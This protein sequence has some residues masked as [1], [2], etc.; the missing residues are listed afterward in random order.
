MT[1]TVL[2]NTKSI[3][4]Q[5]CERKLLWRQGNWV[6]WSLC[7]EDKHGQEQN[8]CL[9]PS[10]AT[11]QPCFSPTSNKVI[12][13]SHRNYPSYIQ[14]AG[15]RHQ[16]TALRA[17]QAKEKEKNSA[18]RAKSLR[19][20]RRSAGCSEFWPSQISQK[21]E[22]RRMSS[23]CQP[24]GPTSAPLV[25][26]FSLVLVWVASLMQLPSIALHGNKVLRPSLCIGALH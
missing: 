1:S 15:R 13:A 19:T 8:R 25:D 2:Y 17:L 24:G 21:P 16:H 22:P 6:V 18:S 12:S 20:H 5:L 23:F 9:R 26:A 3:M 11:V 14:M 7:W 4:F 10:F